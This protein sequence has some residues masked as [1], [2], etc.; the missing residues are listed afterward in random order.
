MQNQNEQDIHIMANLL[1]TIPLFET[2]DEQMHGEI[3]KHAI[4]EYYPENHQLFKEGDAADCMYI[5]KSGIVRI[6]HAGETASFDKELAMLGDNDFFGE[7]ALI[8]ESP[9]NATA[10][11]VQ[12]TQVFIIKKEDFIKLISINPAVAEKI[13]KELLDR[14]RQNT[15]EKH[16]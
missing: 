11:T 13:S 10:K 16:A 4:M 7:M 6:Y 2:L 15:R 9:R 8:S 5:I 14:V 1:K 12:A 3:I